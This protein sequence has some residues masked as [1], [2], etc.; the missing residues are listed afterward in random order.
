MGFRPPGAEP[1]HFAAL[2]L[3]E[4]PDV[5]FL[6]REPHLLRQPGIGRPPGHP[7]GF[8]QRVKSLV[9]HV[10]CRA[11]GSIRRRPQGACA[12]WV[13]TDIGPTDKAQ[14]NRAVAPAIDDGTVHQHGG[15]VA[16]GA[17]NMIHR[18]GNARL[19]KAGLRLRMKPALNRLYVRRIW[20]PR[21]ARIRLRSR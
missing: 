3:I 2:L 6:W 8:P 4:H 10:S 1:D 15:A 5:C 17:F 21:Y 16:A 12:P 7:L 18:P 13:T 20:P 9:R 11:G 19:S 14:V